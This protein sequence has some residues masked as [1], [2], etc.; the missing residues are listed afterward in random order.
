MT[1]P[2]AK[3][4]AVVSIA[5]LVLAPTALRMV[6]AVLPSALPWQQICT[7]HGERSVQ[8]PG[9]P[10]VP[11]TPNQGGMGTCDCPLC[12]LCHLGWGAPAPV[13]IP[14]AYVPRDGTLTPVADTR[15][16]RLAWQWALQNPRAPP[17]SI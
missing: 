11:A 14:V 1:R 5:W 10:G 8:Q 15:P 2:L 12:V 7:S 6:S 3:W 13:V 4:L 16:S 17:A 9:A